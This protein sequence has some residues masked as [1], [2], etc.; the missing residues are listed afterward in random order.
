M[1][2]NNHQIK[3]I[4]H[5]VRTL[6]LVFDLYKQKN[7]TQKLINSAIFSEN[8]SIAREILTKHGKEALYY[9]KLKEDKSTFIYKDTL[10]AYKIRSGDVIV[11]GDPVGPGYEIQEAISKFDEFCTQHGWKLCFFQCSKHYLSHFENTGFT[12]IKIGSEAI[13]D[14]ENFNLIG[15]KKKDFRNR[16]RKLEKLGFF[17]KLYTGNISDQ[18]FARLQIISNEWLDE[19]NRVERGFSLGYFSRKYIADSQIMTVENEGGEI[20]AFINLIPS[21][22]E[23]QMT[24]DLMRKAKNAP[25]GIMDYLFVQAILELQTLGYS[26]LSLGLTPMSGFQAGEEI[27]LAELAVNSIF[28][29]L[30]FLFNYEGLKVFKDKFATSWEPKFLAF[31]NIPQLPRLAL[32]IKKVLEEID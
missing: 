10:I 4:F 18:L 8:H 5:N 28:K 15:P 6:S 20:I 23:G 2:Q 31:K 30:N 21:Y 27:S 7:L 3:N 29:R 22:Q 16:I 19:P 24:I 9:F 26:S 1:A 14:L 32:S 11:L 13:V 25:S 12:R 17:T